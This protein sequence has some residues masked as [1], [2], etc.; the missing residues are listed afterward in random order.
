[1]QNDSNREPEKR[2]PKFEALADT[3]E[4]V[5]ENIKSRNGKP[6]FPCG[7]DVLDRG[8]FGLHRA[9][10]TVVAARPGVGKTALV[11]QLAMNLARA[12]HRVAFLSLEMTKETIIER[13]FCLDQGVNG[14][15]LLMGNVD[16]SVDRKIARF[17][18]DFAQLPIRVIDDYCHTE[19][20]L[21]TLVD[22]LEFRPDVLILDHI[23]HIR[24]VNGGR[25]TQW[26]LLTD[27]LRYLKEVAMRYKIAV[28]VLSQINR[29]GADE[30]SLGNLKGTGAIEEMADHVL[31]MHEPEEPNDKGDN[32]KI[33][34]AKNRFGPVGYFDMFTERSTFRFFNSKHE[35]ELARLHEDKDNQGGQK[36]QRD[37][38]EGSQGGVR[39]V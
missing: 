23:Q 1:M 14:F 7:L 3:V 21:Y 24:G 39:E 27:Y 11:C 8:I 10:M 36:I 34:V 5:I 9:Q 26:E 15:D 29:S 4:R 18:N 32:M 37:R 6:E 22:H 30:P 38:T 2:Y 35:Y 13:M 19:N 33:Y 17:A 25:Q 20:E 16:K 12:K 28:V 31:L